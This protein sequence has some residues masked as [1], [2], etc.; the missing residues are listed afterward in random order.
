MGTLH[1]DQYTFSIISRSVLP[2]V[3]NVSDKRRE[4]DDIVH[5]HCM[6]DTKGYKY[7]F[8]LCN[9]HGFSTATLDSRTRLNVTLYVHGL[10]CLI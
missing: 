3:K 5:V 6:L 7:I 4:T 2:T 1:E 10:S 8:R 9:T